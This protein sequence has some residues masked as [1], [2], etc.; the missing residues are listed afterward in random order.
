MTCRFRN[1]NYKGLLL[2]LTLIIGRVMH[3]GRGVRVPGI[4]MTPRMEFLLRRRAVA[5]GGEK[6]KVG[7]GRFG[8]GSSSARGISPDP[9]LELLRGTSEEDQNTFKRNMGTHGGSDVSSVE[10]DNPQI[11]VRVEDPAGTPCL[12]SFKSGKK[13][14]RT[15]FFVGSGKRKM[16]FLKLILISFFPSVSFQ[17]AGRR[18][19]RFLKTVA[20]LGVAGLLHARTL[21]TV[22]STGLLLVG[23]LLDVAR[24]MLTV[25]CMICRIRWWTGLQAMFWGIWTL[26]GLLHDVG[27]MFSGVIRYNS[28]IQSTRALL[29]RYA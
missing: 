25:L 11:G 6:R 18:I 5:E 21:L 17:G 7:K 19:C 12:E 15:G 22:T 26:W 8:G 23:T 20:L 4:R 29:N 16:E 24:M 14:L 3:G 27:R 10:G 13:F 28:R 2:R 1:R 9:L